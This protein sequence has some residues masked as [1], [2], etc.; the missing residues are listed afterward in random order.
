M[1]LVR[2]RQASAGDSFSGLS[3]GASSMS[4]GH[5]AAVGQQFED[6]LLDSGCRCVLC[7][8]VSSLDLVSAVQDW[9]CNLAGARVI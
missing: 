7:C 1:Q 4:S 8:A 6:A 2:S 3:T 5:L 9:S